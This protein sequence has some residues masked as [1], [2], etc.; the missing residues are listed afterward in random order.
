M[1]CFVGPLAK[2]G[3]VGVRFCMLHALQ[4][5]MGRNLSADLDKVTSVSLL[6][7]SMRPNTHYSGIAE[8]LTSTSC[9]SSPAASC[10]ATQ[11][12]LK[13]LDG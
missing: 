1:V 2:S 9:Y 11:E 13:L 4:T 8:C 12:P 6:Q 5:N 7:C 3:G 10:S